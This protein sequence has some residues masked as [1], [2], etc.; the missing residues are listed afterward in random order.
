MSSFKWFVVVDRLLVVSLMM[1]GLTDRRTQSVV[2]EVGG[3][4]ISDRTVGSA[5]DPS[6]RSLVV[7]VVVEVW[8]WVWFGE[9]AAM[10]AALVGGEKRI[11]WI[12]RCRS[13]WAVRSSIICR[14][15]AV[16]GALIVVGEESMRFVDDDE[17]EV[18]CAL[19]ESMEKYG[20]LLI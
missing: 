10:K 2:E 17:E 18:S 16:S 19:I 14:A 5:V 6:V 11:V 1:F 20:C 9:A 12:L 15:T 8:L 4:E 3:I 7:V 13:C